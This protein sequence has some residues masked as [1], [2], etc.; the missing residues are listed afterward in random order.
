[1][2]NT[3]LIKHGNGVP[4]EK[5]HPYELGYCDDNG[6]L[7]IGGDYQ[8]DEEG[9]IETDDKNNPK[10]GEAKSIIPT[11]FLPITGGTISG[12]IKVQISTEGNSFVKIHGNR[13]EMSDDDNDDG[14]YM[15]SEG[16]QDEPRLNLYGNASN[17]PV[18][19]GGVASPQNGSDAVNKNYIVNNFA[20]KKHTS[21]S[22]EYGGATDQLYGH[23]TLSDS[24]SS[25]VN[26]TLHVAATPKAVKTVYD[27]ANMK[28]NADIVSYGTWTPTIDNATISKYKCSYIKIGNVCVISFFINGIG[29]SSTSTSSSYYV[30]IRGVPF[31]PETAADSATT[32]DA[33]V[34]WYGGGG[35]AQGFTTSDNSILTGFVLDDQTILARTNTKGYM[36]IS[37]GATNFYTAGTIA[38]VTKE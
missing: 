3:I 36:C 33:T 21:A 6:L 28:L 20:S 32:T 24:I 34:N 5:L 15:C 4:N 35:H 22:D 7:Y 27:L 26:A 12:P 13:I 10:L 29:S 18:I 37:N 23:V 38:Y 9:N 16:T 30:R 1:M 25:N 17:I 31:T 2:S 19:I 11:N 14:L 8:R